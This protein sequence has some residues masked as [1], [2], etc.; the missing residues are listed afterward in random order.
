V[1]V[2]VRF[3][4]SIREITKKKEIEI[5]AAS[6]KMRVLDLINILCERLG[7]QFKEAILDSQ[8]QAVKRLIKIM[9]NGR[10]IESINGFNTM[11]KDQDIVQILPPIGGG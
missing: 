8:T 11:V 9:V 6:D 4:S 2:R 5:E 1:R 3:F 7:A 10:N